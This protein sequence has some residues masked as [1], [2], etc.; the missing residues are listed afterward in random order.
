MPRIG[1]QTSYTKVYHVILRG[2]DKQDIFLIERDYSKFLE[3]IGDTKEKFD[4]DIYAYCLMSNHVHIIIYD[5]MQQ[6]SK[7]VQSV[8]IKYSMY[9]NKKYDRV[10]HLFQA[11]FLSKQIESREYLKSACRYIHQN[12]LKA[13]IEKTEKYKWSSYK[14]YTKKSK[15]INPQMLLLTFAQNQQD[16]IKEFIKFHNIE[17]EQEVID[18]IEY[19]LKEKLSDEELLRYI[20][21]FLKMKY[22]DIRAMLVND[23]NKRNEIIKQCKKIKGIT[24]RQL[25]RI[26]GINRKVIDRTK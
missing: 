16:A 10:G 24:N 2:I 15:I 19:E 23:K 18:V 26:L 21:K 7:I 13:G 3:I 14:E 11:R 8:A 20:C 9:F 22:T 1:R 25:A 6:I 17:F 12:P 4:F 5:K